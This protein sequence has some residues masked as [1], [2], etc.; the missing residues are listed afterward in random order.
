MQNRN[1]YI[2]KDYEDKYANEVSKIII[3][4]LLKVNSLDY[5]LE[6]VQKTINEFTPKCVKEIFSRR[7]KVFIALE[8]D[9]IVGTASI[10]KSWYN[11]DGEY[12]I[13]TVFVDIAYHRH[14]IGRMLINKV[15]EFAKT[16][17]AKKLVIPASITGCEFY[18]KLGYEYKDGK[19]ELNEDKMYIMEKYL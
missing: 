16:I 3:E 9:K 8:Q 19:K 2:I 18:H 12:W 10:D 6:F 15:E 7:T 5:G 11:N 4:N 17:P 14:G 13:L 1:L